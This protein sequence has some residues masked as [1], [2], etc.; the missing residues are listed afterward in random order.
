MISPVVMRYINE[1]PTIIV[2]KSESVF[3]TEYKKS[4]ILVSVKGSRIAEANFR[5]RENTTI[6]ITGEMIEENIKIRPLA[7][8]AFFINTFE[9]IMTSKPSDR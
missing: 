6:W 9:A 5:V 7:P 1:M 4:E 2:T 8:T 3:P